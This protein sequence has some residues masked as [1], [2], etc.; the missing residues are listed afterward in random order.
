MKKYIAQV[1]STNFVYPNHD[2][3]EYDT[4]ILHD[5]N[6]HSVSGTVESFQFSQA[7][8]PEDNLIICRLEFTWSLNDAEPF[9]D[10]EGN[11]KLLSVHALPSTL[12]YYKPWHLEEFW[13]STDN[14]ITGYT[15]AVSYFGMVPKDYGLT[16]FYNG[17]YFFE[18]RFIGHRSIYTI[19]AMLTVT[20]LTT[21]GQITLDSAT[22]VAGTQFELAFSGESNECWGVMAQHSS[23]NVNWVGSGW[24]SCNSPKQTFVEE[25][26]GD[27]YF[28]VVQKDNF[29]V[30]TYSNVETYSF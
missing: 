10:D 23:D 15:S 7:T 13:N 5:I 30:L 28:R 18:F 20:G 9:I 21:M 6:H 3:S 22:F 1:D 11:L 14:T 29:G 27:W 8:P 4:Y 2:I 16:K 19:G 25:A 24:Q 17:D 12:N 26:I